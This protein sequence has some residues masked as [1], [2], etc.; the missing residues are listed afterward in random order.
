MIGSSFPLG[1][2]IISCLHN[3]SEVM[4]LYRDLI[5]SVYAERLNY[6]IEISI[7]D[8]DLDS[9]KMLISVNVPS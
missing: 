9:D 4:R 5:S 8:A 6:F 7:S 3:F 2:K 1:S